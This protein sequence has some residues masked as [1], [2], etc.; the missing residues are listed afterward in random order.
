VLDRGRILCIG[1]VEEVQNSDNDRVQDL[2]NRRPS[3]EEIDGEDYL[4]RLTL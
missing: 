1:T 4:R 3:S 2:L